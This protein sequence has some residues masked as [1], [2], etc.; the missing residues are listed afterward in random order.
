MIPITAIINKSLSS[1]IV[2]PEFK[3][4]IVTPILKKPTL[5]QNDLKNYRPVSNLSFL[6]KL[7]EKVVIQQTLKHL[8]TNNLAE[9]FQ[10][11]YRKCHSTE[12][13]LLK[14]MND[15]LIAADRKECSLFTLLDLST[16]FDT[17]DHEI[18]L[19]RLEISF[20]FSGTVLNWFRSYVSGR[21]QTVSAAEKTS[22]PAPLSFGVPQGSVLGPLLFVIYTQPLGKL[23]SNLGLSY[24]FYADDTQMYSSSCSPNCDLLISNTQT[25]VQAIKSWMD[26]NKLKLNQDKTEIM[27]I[28]SSNRVSSAIPESV[29][30]GNDTVRLLTVLKIWVSSST[31]ISR[32]LNKLI[33]SENLCFWNSGEFRKLDH[34]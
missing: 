32:C 11:A 10:S 33:V 2:P 25:C 31:M 22:E 7:L 19:Q 23:I 14:I 24:H 28:K 26:S 3:R 9:P 4:A 12:T 18:L 21:Y 20:G 27:F 29:N 6:S 13:A 34:F 1:G 15:L 30:L 5:D 16:A 17:I 8:E